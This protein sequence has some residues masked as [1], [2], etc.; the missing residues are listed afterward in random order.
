M[1]YCFDVK[2]DEGVV[3]TYGMRFSL[4]SPE[5]HTPPSRQS[6]AFPSLLPLISAQASPRRDKARGWSLVCSPFTLDAHSCPRIY[7][8][9]NFADCSAVSV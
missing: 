5:S 9:R 7:V 6:L 1:G 4:G 8:C 3:K 2:D